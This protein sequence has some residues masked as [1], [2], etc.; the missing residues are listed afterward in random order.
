MQTGS[1]IHIQFAV[2][3]LFVQGSL[4]QFGGL[5]H[6]RGR[7]HALH[8]A[9]IAWRLVVY[10]GILVRSETLVPH[11]GPFDEAVLLAL[12]AFGVRPYLGL[13]ECSGGGGGEV[14]LLGGLGL[15]LGQPHGQ[16]L[17]HQ[18]VDLQVV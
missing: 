5:E 13:G 7:W 2:E 12:P 16:V 11:F 10:K 1:V 8:S 9:L 17:V 18:H 15:E 6:P 14:S 3:L 4:V